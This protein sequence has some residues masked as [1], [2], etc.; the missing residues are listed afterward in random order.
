MILSSLAE[1]MHVKT[2]ETS[3]NTDLDMQELLDID[4]TLQ[5]V[6]EINKCIKKDSK[7]F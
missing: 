7:K 1:G 3:Q 5:S 6:H 4:K 2:R